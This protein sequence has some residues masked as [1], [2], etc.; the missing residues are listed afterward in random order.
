MLGSSRCLAVSIGLGSGFQESKKTKATPTSY[1]EEDLFS[2]P[3]RP[4][5]LRN[6][7]G[8]KALAMQVRQN[9][10]FCLQAAF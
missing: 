4:V 9:I 10:H 5:G 1:G 8:L 6:F 3:P 7:H 2:A